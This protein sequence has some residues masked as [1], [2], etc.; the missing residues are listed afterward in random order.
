MSDKK[1]N[2]TAADDNLA[3]SQVDHSEKDRMLGEGVSEEAQNDNAPKNVA[4]M[5]PMSPV[6]A[7]A[8][9]INLILATGPFR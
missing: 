1:I 3:F 5:M 7:S 8:T 9:V 4:V 2:K 6:V